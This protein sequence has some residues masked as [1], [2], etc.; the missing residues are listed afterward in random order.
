MSPTAFYILLIWVVLTIAAV[1]LIAG[2]FRS[3]PRDDSD[4][5]NWDV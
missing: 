2:I 5:Q 4:E 3:A 1:V